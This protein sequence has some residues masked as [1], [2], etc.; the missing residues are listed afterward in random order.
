MHRHRHKGGER[1]SPIGD[2]G[3]WEPLLLTLLLPVLSGALKGPLKG[4]RKRSPKSINFP[5]LILATSGPGMPRSPKMGST[6]VSVSLAV[7]CGRAAP[8]ATVCVAIDAGCC[9]TVE[10]RELTPSPRGWTSE[11]LARTELGLEPPA[12]GEP[13]AEATNHEGTT[14]QTQGGR[15]M[16]H[17]HPHQGCGKLS[18]P[19]GLT[20]RSPRTRLVVPIRG[21]GKAKTTATI[22][23]LNEIFNLTELMTELIS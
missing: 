20:A 1:Q 2:R 22:N 10:A 16:C 14:G 19:S 3:H 4:L 11:E 6:R 5:S 17:N 18:P 12:S 23:N 15:C 7:D 13:A 8:A 21:R 9:G